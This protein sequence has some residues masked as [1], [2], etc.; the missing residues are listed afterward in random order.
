MR[1]R[2]VA[3]LLLPVLVAA[4]SSCG[5]RKPFSLST[6][7][8]VPPKLVQRATPSYTD[9]ARR[10]Q[11]TGNVELLVRIGADGKPE[12][13]TVTKSLD[14]VHGLDEAA[15][16]AVKRFVFTPATLNGKPVPVDDVPI[17]LSFGLY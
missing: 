4:V 11:V 16:S 15:I 3:L 10:A 14:K 8:L 17:T 6:P 1:L 13:A 7:N 2:A 9:E 12:R 5:A